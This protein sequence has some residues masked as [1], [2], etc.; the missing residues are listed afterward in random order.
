MKNLT[1]YISEAKGQPIDQQWIDNEKPVM[2]SDGRQV[3]IM[4]IDISVVP[5]K[6]TG[7]VKMS[8]D[9]LCDYEWDDTG[10]CVKASDRMGN[11]KKPDDADNLVKQI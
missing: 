11:P 10:K 2:T 5:N 8:D 6:I 9:K 7:K 1:D 3:M 4:D